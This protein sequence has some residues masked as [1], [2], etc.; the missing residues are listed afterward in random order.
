VG[1]KRMPPPTNFDEFWCD[2]YALAHSKLETQR[3]HVR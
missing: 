1:N 3:W 2:V